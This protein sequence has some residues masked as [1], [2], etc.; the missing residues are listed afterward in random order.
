MTAYNP[1][2]DKYKD[3]LFVLID[4]VKKCRRYPPSFRPSDGQSRYPEVNGE[5]TCGEFK[6]N[7]LSS[8]VSAR[9]AEDLSNPS[10]L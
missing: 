9:V 2:R 4:T 7:L 1:E 10:L 8:S 5:S 6:R 3:C